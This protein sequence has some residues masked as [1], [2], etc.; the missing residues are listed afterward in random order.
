MEY[1]QFNTPQRWLYDHSICTVGL[2]QN[3]GPFAI[4]VG[5][6][7]RCEANTTGTGEGS[8]RTQWRPTKTN[9]ARREPVQAKENIAIAYPMANE[10][11]CLMH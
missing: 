2:C 8:L 10:S 4:K 9:I 7:N 5:A 1:M 3:G 11:I 6:L